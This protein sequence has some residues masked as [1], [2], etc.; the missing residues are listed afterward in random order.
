MTQQKKIFLDFIK[1]IF[2][3]IFSV[4]CFFHDNLSFNFSFG[5]IMICD[6]LSGILIFIINYYFVIPK[7][8]KNQKLVK[9]LFF[10]ESIVLILISLSLFFNPFIT[11][12]FLRNIFKINN[13]VSY[14]IIVHSM[15]ELYVSYLKINKPIIPLNFFIYL[16]LFGLGFY[17]LGKQLNLTSFI[18][19]CL[20]FIFLIL[21][22]LFSVSLW[23]N[24]KFLRDQNK[25]IEK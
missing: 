10:V 9:F 14:I 23:K 3:L 19:Y 5:K 21:A 4:S 8:V 24:I 25:K 22:L 1:I 13:I 12:N 7:I 16:S 11:N 17:I 15:V 20:S 6:I 18:F 2:S